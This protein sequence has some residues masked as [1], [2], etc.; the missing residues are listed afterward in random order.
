LEDPALEEHV[1]VVKSWAA[2]IG[3]MDPDTRFETLHPAGLLLQHAEE[4]QF[5]ADGTD[6]DRQ[7]LMHLL[8]NHFY[9]RYQRDGRRQS[10]GELAKDY[11]VYRRARAL[12]NIDDLLDNRSS[13]RSKFARTMIQFSRGLVDRDQREAPLAMIFTCSFGGGHKSA[14]SAVSQYLKADGYDVRIADTTR[15]ENFQTAAIKM[16]D[17]Y[18]NKIVLEKQWYGLGN[19]VDRSNQLMSGVLV[20]SCP[21][22]V[23]DSERKEQF[24]SALLLARPSLIVTVYHMDLMIVLELAK[25]M[26]N[27]PLIH[28]ATDMDI[29]MHEV[30]DVRPIYP[31]MLVGVPFEVDASWSTI[32]PLFRNQT[33]LSGYPVRDT[34]LL[35]PVEKRVQEEKT[36]RYPLNAKLVLVMSGGGGQDVPW[37]ELLAKNGL[38]GHLVH[39]VVVAGGNNDFEP[40]LRSRLGG[41]VNFT[42]R[43]L[44]Q[45][46]SQNVTVEVARDAANQNRDKP[47]FVLGA[48]LAL[49]M[50]M[51]DLIIT[52]PGGGTT[53]EVAYRGPPVV[54]DASHGL[55][56]WE[57]FTVEQ[58]EQQKRGVRLKATSGSAL[59]QACVDALALGRSTRLA[60][61]PGSNTLLDTQAR[62]Q[63]AARD[64]M[65]RPCDRCTVFPVQT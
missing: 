29:K 31:R 56:H 10:F 1:S 37:P 16:G 35:D 21:A 27:L 5:K 22:P 45:G 13:P 30:F 62:V 26:G 51:A 42:G 41:S 60:T 9:M 55:L 14:S 52:K 61:Q 64:V 58:F 53:A 48:E 3:G 36:R 19:L 11:Q 18:F 44:L 25:E 49:L 57:E 8:R 34:F 32:S 12:F 59:R 23:C 4:E 46:A 6:Q 17:Y 28:I 24:R 63:A 54:F 47:F 38:D 40:K 20:K 15:D 65:S 43:T 7:V 50:D 33:F 2:D 39:V